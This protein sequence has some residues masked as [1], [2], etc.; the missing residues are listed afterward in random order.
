MKWNLLLPVLLLPGLIACGKD[1]ED[2]DDE[3][4]DCPDTADCDDGTTTG[5]TTTTGGGGGTPS[6]SVTW[7]G[8]SVDVAVSGGGGAWWF[9][10]VETGSG[11]GAGECWTGEDC[12]YGY[13]AGGT[14]FNYCHDAGDSGTSLSYGGDPSALAAGTTVFPSAE[15]DGLTTY[16][17]E[18]DPEFGGDGQCYVWG[19]DPG[20]YSGLGCTEL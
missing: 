12:V 19:D 2:E 14:V 5:G 17:L 15:Y 10:L 8:S 6:A 3:D 20:Y 7:G 18:S 1:D 4:D 13:D 16:Y 11:C 9:G